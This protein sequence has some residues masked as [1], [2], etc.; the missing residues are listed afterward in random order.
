MAATLAGSEQASRDRMVCR[1]ALRYA[2]F[3]GKERCDHLARSA[4]VL[5][6]LCDPGFSHP[7]ALAAVSAGPVEWPSRGR[8]LAR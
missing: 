5:D 8:G 4:V 1:E 3:A 2:H 6:G 7:P